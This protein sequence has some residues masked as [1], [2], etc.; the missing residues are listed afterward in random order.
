ME[1]T[2]HHPVFVDEVTENIQTF[3]KNI[4]IERL[5]HSNIDVLMRG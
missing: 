5:Q 1:Q 3:Q 2:K 4:L